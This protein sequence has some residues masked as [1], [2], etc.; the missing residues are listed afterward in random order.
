LLPDSG[1]IFVQISDENLH[2]VRMLLDE[3]F[4][5]ANFVSQITYSK[6]SGATVV[7]LPGTADYI[8]WYARNRELVKY[9]PLFLEK[10]LGG[11]GA[12]KYNQVIMPNWTLAK[13]LS[14]RGCI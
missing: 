12:G 7:L 6:T 5:P 1:S 3:V 11:D 13:K 8:L 9:R 4:G 10:Q 14:H 2:R